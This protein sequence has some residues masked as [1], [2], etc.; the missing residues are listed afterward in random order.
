MLRRRP[1]PREIA[2]RPFRNVL[3]TLFLLSGFAALL[4]EVVWVRRLSFLFGGGVRCAG[5][6]VA[7]T[8]AGLALGSRWAGP[9]ADRAGRPL[10]GYALL[11]GGIALW[12]FATPYLFRMLPG[13][14]A[15]FSSLAG[16]RR[17]DLDPAA[18]LATALLLL[19]GTLLMGATTP[20]VV[21]A[22]L[23]S[24]NRSD[25]DASGQP[26]TGVALGRMVG[27][28]T[29][30]GAAGA[31]AAVFLFLPLL[32]MGRTV[33]LAATI[34][35]GIALAAAA[36]ARDLQPITASRAVPGASPVARPG[37]DPWVSRR[38]VLLA[39]FIA[40]AAGAVSQVAWTR[41][42][43]LLFGSSTHALGL[44][45]AAYLGGLALG[46]LW[47]P[48]ALRRS[49]FPGNV[50]ARA[51]LLA[52]TATLL[53]LPVWGRFP[54]LV[55]LV[56]QQTIPS[57][58]SALS[59]QALL[60]LL[61]LLIPAAAL[62]ALLPVL[63]AVLSGGPARAGRD[64]GDA[65]S[66]DTWGSVAG[67]LA[68]PFLLLP[69]LGAESALRVAVLLELALLPLLFGWRL[70]P[71]GAPRGARMRR[72]V[73]LALLAGIALFP[74]WDP[75]LMTSGPAL[76]S[77]SYAGKARRGWAAVAEAIRHRGRLVF[78]EEGSEA[79]VTVRQLAGG[80]LS[81]QINGKTDAST[82]GDLQAQLLAGHLPS[83]LHPSPRKGL[84][85]GLASGIT[86][87][88]VASHPLERI[89][90]VEISPAVARAAGLFREANGGV[91]DDPRFRLRLGDG[92]A[93]LHRTGERYDVIA[94]QPTNPWIAGVTNL[95]TREFF[96]LARDRLAAGG[97]IAVWVQG[98]ALDT[99]D[100]RSI[101]GT[102]LHV[103]PEAQLWEESAA[104]GDYFLIG[105]N[106]G[107]WTTIEELSARI[108]APGLRR[109][110]E[111]AGV[112][113]AADL[114]GRFVTGPEGLSLLSRNAPRVTDDNL[115]LEFTAPRALWKSTEN[116][117]ASLLDSVRR[118]PLDL[119]PPPPGPAG[120]ALRAR[121]AQVEAR[122]RT[123][124]RLALS[125]R[126]A[127]R[128]SLTS[129]ALSAAVGLI[130]AGRYETAL[131]LLRIARG[132]AP[133]APVVPLMAGWLL[134][135]RGD[136][137]EA[138]GAF[139]EALA[140]DPFSGEAANGLGL[141]A[142]RRGDLAGAGQRFREASRLS[143]EETDPPNNLASVL[144]AT[145]RETEALHLLESVLARHPL[146][147]PA[148]INR[149]VALARLGRL[150]EAI[151]EYQKALELQ[152][153]N[154]DAAYN[155]RRAR[156]RLEE[157]SREGGRRPAQEEGEPGAGFV[158]EGEVRVWLV[159]GSGVTF[160]PATLTI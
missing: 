78:V 75:E 134:L 147:V 84:V 29:A 119:F 61:V 88:A 74:R 105:R 151:A 81:L 120:E 39:L 95:F 63:T 7:L 33:L 16:G 130:R 41:T 21:R 125:L 141:A 144:L 1:R 55:S 143:P 43:V 94:S 64:C 56:L 91:L 49:S 35:I 47:A 89:D 76:Y 73:T 114:L 159:E 154:E 71:E 98:Y 160:S 138:E 59:L 128:E 40:G 99:E 22:A 157:T 28:N 70:G 111:R 93:H 37:R 140:L 113:D 115:R 77:A 45:L 18:L 54:V 24:R 158:G 48:R 132:Q 38:R 108:G 46:S 17:I 19:P 11:E 13:A 103:F 148:R 87:A 12:A 126:V 102:F 83:L 34:E 51:L 5:A 3:P 27:W 36:I 20:F 107:D 136:L 6:V 65:Y 121:L 31:L 100:F 116:D 25:A 8:L 82:G 62:G 79:T 129:P 110:L 104:G 117:L 118:S 146:H 124:L 50:A 53:A 32:G 122:R 142:Y 131:P 152:P 15:V 150:E 97:V 137:L 80:T 23:Q 72:S 135:D 57:F 2:I 133:E 123:R 149:G 44:V 127:D 96:L 4:L 66:L 14:A 42:L 67:S 112:Q 68:S 145:G 153:L 58:A 69:R 26:S 109:E 52:A 106:G 90:C 85:I 30:G 86:A 139:A 10:F 155:L 60:S 9:R 101:A 156:E 92:R